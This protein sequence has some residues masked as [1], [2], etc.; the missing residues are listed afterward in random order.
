MTS[1]LHRNIQT[2]LHDP[3]PCGIINCITTRKL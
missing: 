2:Q 1:A 3:Q